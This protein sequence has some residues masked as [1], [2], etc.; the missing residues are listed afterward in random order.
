MDVIFAPAKLNLFLE[1]I[2]RREDNYH[3]IETVFCRVGLYDVIYCYLLKDSLAIEVRTLGMDIRCEEN[4]VYK[5]V[6]LFFEKIGNRFGV[7]IEL[8]KYIP[9]GAG[10]GGGSSDAASVLMW[11]FDKMRQIGMDV[12]EDVVWQ[13]GRQI[14][15][16]VPFFLTKKKIALGRE[17]GDVI[18]EV[19]IDVR[20]KFLII[21]PRIKVSTA[22]IYNGLKLT[23]NR[24]SVN[25]FT[26]ALDEKLCFFNRLQEVACSM[27]QG[28]RQFLETVASLVSTGVY[29]TGSGSAV[30]CPVYSDEDINWVGLADVVAQRGFS[31]WC[32]DPV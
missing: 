9:D 15:C 4:L 30:F 22:A 10:L 21:F 16:D 18:E 28:Y 13:V 24:A 11:L 14:G 29:M 12:D 8:H 3:N 23:H 25:M 20:H 17:R 19:N 2:S 1:V 27:V 5:A 6:N 7:Y 26:S 32:V 31:L